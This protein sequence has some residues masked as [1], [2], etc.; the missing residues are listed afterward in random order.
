[1]R[2]EDTSFSIWHRLPIRGE[3]GVIHVPDFVVFKGAHRMS[4]RERNPDIIIECRKLPAEQSNR[5][6]PRIVRDVIGFSLDT[7]PAISIL[8]TDRVLS[9]YARALAREYGVGMISVE[10]STEPQHDLFRMMMIQ[11]QPS[12]EKMKRMLQKG[13]YKLENYYRIRKDQPSSSKVSRTP[14]K[15]DANEARSGLRERVLKAMKNRPGMNVTQLS[16]TLGVH[17][18]YILNELHILEKEGRAKVAKRSSMAD[19]YKHDSWSA[20][21]KDTTI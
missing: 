21:H 12:R 15:T 8:V 13:V 7:L 3:T 11:G 4:P 6:D 9:E 18:D 19:G 10:G 5:T 14:Q 16:S 1:M 2:S 17:V 20:T